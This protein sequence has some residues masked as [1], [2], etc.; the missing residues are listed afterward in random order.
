[1]QSIASDF[2]PELRRKD[3]MT[4]LISLLSHDQPPE[5]QD[6]AAFGLANLAKDFANKTAIRNAG[7]I[8]ALVHLL[9]SAD[10]DVKKMSGH[11]LA[12]MLEDFASRTEI[13]Y[14]HGLAPLLELLASEYQE[15]QEHALNS[16]IRAAED[17]GNRVEIREINGVRRIIDFLTQDVP[18]LHYLALMCL[19]NCLEDV[20]TSKS[21]FEMGGLSA[22]V[23]L[24]GAEDVRTKRNAAL[25]LS[26]A[27]RI[28]R[29]QI[30]IRDAGALPALLSNLAH[31]DV[32]TASNAALALAELGKS[33]TNQLELGKLGAPEALIK[34]VSHDD[35]E[36]PRQCAAALASL[37]LNEIIRAEM[38]KA[39]IV[40]SLMMVLSR[41][42]PK[43]QSAA[44]MALGRL[45]QDSEGR[46][47]LTREPPG[48]GLQRIIELIAS[49]DHAVCKSAAYALS[50]AALNDVS[51]KFWLCD[52]LT[53]ANLITDGFYDIGSAGTHPTL[54]RSFPLLQELKDAPLDKR[55]EILLLDS[56]TDPYL[57]GLVSLVSSEGPLHARTPR[58]QIR[59]IAS[60]VAQV[61]GGPAHDVSNLQAQSYKFK[62]TEL[63]LKL[64][65]NVVPLGS[66]AQGTF[67]HRALLFKYV[68]DKVGLAPV[69]LVRGDY[70]RAWNVVDVSRQTLAPPRV[71]TPA[72]SAAPSTPSKLEKPA[73]SAR[74]RENADKTSKDKDKDREKDKEKDGAG[75]G[76]SGGANAA[77]GMAGSGTPST[78]TA[79]GP[80]VTQP[81]TLVPIVI[82]EPVADEAPLSE[83]KTIVDLMFVPGRLMLIGSPEADQ[84]QRL[85]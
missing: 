67:Y 50:T 81:T 3:L 2:H 19:A 5:V 62:I 54:P 80:Q 1:M 14:V 79:Q 35:V 53:A 83:E 47:A 85:T 65:S 75:G 40:H 34:N 27:A 44:A 63:K 70:G 49:K 12:V 39:N 4:T 11:A 78:A 71:A 60:V 25:T 45:L 42:D 82:P 41:S 51:A 33:E 8:K 9:D 84:Y 18:E 10:P 13:R 72:A 43:L 7:G 66:V 6:E 20:T 58:Q 69:T 57:A 59:Q 68:C 64:G 29:N 37:C 36:V 46:F 73:K 32:L 52:E 28:E 30:L 38:V 61:L 21:I 17:P 26:K 15:V 74:T 48:S 56:T 24:L 77:G 16:L 76:G 55:R 23:K 31:S 22:L